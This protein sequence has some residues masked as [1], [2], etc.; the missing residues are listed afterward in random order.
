MGGTVKRSLLIYYGGEE[1]YD[2]FETLPN[3]GE[4]DDYEGAVAALNRH[5][6]PQLN[7][8][9]EKFKFRRA[10]QTDTESVDMFYAR[11]RRLANT[12]PFTDQREEI[13]DQIILGCRSKLLRKLILR[14]PKMTLDDILVL[15][16]SHELSDARAEEMETALH[17]PVTA[18]PT[19]RHVPVKEERVDAVRSRPGTPRQARSATSHQSFRLTPGESC[20]YCGEDHPAMAVCGAKGKTCS[21]CGD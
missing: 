15:A 16:R 7:Y 3:T 2:L 14:Q 12:C 13:R 11:L 5:F 17:T 18:P 4:D 10:W 20:G 9:F 21:R 6:D 8:D 1:I 19:I